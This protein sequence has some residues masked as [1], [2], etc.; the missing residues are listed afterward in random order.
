[1]QSNINAPA[2][3]PLHQITIGWNGSPDPE[4]DQL[5][6]DLIEVERAV[7]QSMVIV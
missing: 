3:D 1:M 2:Y 7:H 4:V 6:R 5:L